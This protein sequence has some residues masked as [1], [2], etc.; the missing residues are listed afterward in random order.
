MR[1][2]LRRHLLTFH[3]Y[4]MHLRG[5]SSGNTATDYY[6]AVVASVSEVGFVKNSE[7]LG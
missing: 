7:L 1:P 5:C 4:L 6:F 2:C 3:R